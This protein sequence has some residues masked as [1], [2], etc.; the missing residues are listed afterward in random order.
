MKKDSYEKFL[1]LYSSGKT[2]LR[3]D[4]RKGKIYKKSGKI[5]I[6]NVIP[7]FIENKKALLLGRFR[8]SLGCDDRRTEEFLKTDPWK[9]AWKLLR[10]G[11]FKEGSALD[12]AINRQ[13]IL[14]DSI[15]KKIS[16]DELDR[17]TFSLTN[18]YAF[19]CSGLISKVVRTTSKKFN[20]K[21]KV[22]EPLKNPFSGENV[23]RSRTPSAY[24]F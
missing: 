21:E 14:F 19:D 7:L 23:E 2:F 18:G 5:P 6:V 16:Q 9:F 22:I 13:I 10:K 1:K 24:E 4:K 15:L 11:L 8:D 17:G 20:F 3:Y 12:L